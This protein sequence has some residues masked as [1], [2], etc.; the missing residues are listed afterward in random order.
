MKPAIGLIL[1]SGL[2][3]FAE[4]LS[5]AVSISA[6][7]IPFYP[8]STVQGHAGRL[9]LGT[10]RQDG[11]ESLPLVVLQG[12]VH[13]YETGDLDP[14]LFPV[15]LAAQL[16][17][18]SLIVTNAAGAV[19]RSYSPGDLMLIR[20]TLNLT[21]QSI[22]AGSKT[23]SVS[24]AILDPV[25]AEHFRQNAKS[26]GVQLREGTYCWLKGPSYET[27]AEIEM[28]ARVGADAV[29]MSTVPELTL[30]AASGI[31]TAGLSLLSNMGTGI[32]EEKLSHQEVTDTASR[33]KQRL[34]SLLRSTIMSM[35]QPHQA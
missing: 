28:L 10:I 24:S 11:N 32:R 27:A 30:A 29:G 35:S 26:L 31:R 21:F 9:V 23:K 8:Q 5:P 33:V 12:R 18:S 2:G 7:D 15:R 3:E 25:L 19:N 1:G 6:S 13:F 14:V 17:I 34:S 22:P 16:G 4:E 20:S